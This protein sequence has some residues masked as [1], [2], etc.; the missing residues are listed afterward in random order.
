[1]EWE[2]IQNWEMEKTYAS[3]SIVLHDDIL[4]QATS[5]NFIDEPSYTYNYT[6]KSNIFSVQIKS[7]PYSALNL[8]PANN[9]YPNLSKEKKS[10]KYWKYYSDNLSPYWNPY[11][12]SLATDNGG[13]PL[14]SVVYNNSDWYVYAATQSI[15]STLIDFWNPYVSLQYGKNPNLGDITYINSPLNVDQISVGYQKDSIV[16]YKG[17]FYQSLIDFNYQA[18]DYKQQFRSYD[19]Y[20]EY[21]IFD[22]ILVNKTKVGDIWSSNWK[23]VDS[24]KINPKWNKI[25]IWNPSK[26]YSFNTFTV[27]NDI[28]YV[29]TYS[30]PVNNFVRNG[31]EPGVSLYWNRYYSLEPDTDFVYG[32]NSNPYILMNDELYKINQ[33][34]NK[35]TLE[36]GIK[37]YINKKW[38]NILVNIF[39]NDNSLF[40]LKNSDR[41]ELYTLINKKLTAN[42]F[43]TAIN[44]L[45]NKC[46]FS[47]YIKYV[48]IDENLN[49]KEYDYN[50]IE[51]L[52]IIIFADKPERV[53]FKVDSLIKEPISVDKLKP[54]K[55]INN[56]IITD[57]TEL[58][59]YNNINIAN[60]I[61]E[62]LNYS[63]VVTKYHGISNITEDTIFRFSGN[64]MP[65]FYEIDIFRK[66]NYIT[67]N[68]IQLVFY[69]N[70]D[71]DF[72]FTL[73]KNDTI[74]KETY[75]IYK[76]NYYDQI[77]NII[78]NHSLFSGADFVF[79][80]LDSDSKYLN[81]DLDN[82]GYDVLSIKYIKSYGDIKISATQIE[83]ILLFDIENSSS[84]T[85]IVFTLSAT[86]GHPP[87]EYSFGYTSGLTVVSPSAYSTNNIYTASKQGALDNLDSKIQFT[88][89]AKDSYGAISETG[90]YTLNEGEIETDVDSIFYYEFI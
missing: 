29:A 44:D 6:D 83:P 25:T 24:I 7:S 85:N 89:T 47:D 57:L 81:E 77:I 35:K 58:N 66:D 32:T 82:Q 80:V 59:Y 50:N 79:E 1:M 22:D 64:Y 71:D 45:T 12:A 31:E 10:G 9:K 33:N 84:G 18:P 60:T 16:I 73:T 76:D 90:R 14:N 34:P 74:L 43:I 19:S 62:N 55:I 78:Y 13:Y 42:N 17:E 54:T 3:G 8:V 15:S 88:I 68:E 30:L 86:A 38:K 28:V 69:T 11:K 37:I 53:N 72:V 70:I 5:D 20:E 46:D 48:V 67:Y 26:N 41:D 4:Y 49:I 56:N 52:P 51:E 27:H 87:Y 65:L 23:K 40:N 39:V 36:N 61:K 21:D 75:T 2:I 63:S